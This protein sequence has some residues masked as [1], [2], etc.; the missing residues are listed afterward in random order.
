MDDHLLIWQ[1]T[2]VLTMALKDKIT[3]YIVS[4]RDKLGRV[5]FDGYNFGGDKFD[6]DKLDRDKSHANKSHT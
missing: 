6:R 3:T 1:S 5:K 2:Q 4:G